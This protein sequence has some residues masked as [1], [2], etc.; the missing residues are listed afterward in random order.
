MSDKKKKRTDMLRSSLG[1]HFAGT[2]IVKPKDWDD[3]YIRSRGVKMVRWGMFSTDYLD[4]D[5]KKAF[6]KYCEE[7]SGKV[8]TYSIEDLKKAPE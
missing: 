4:K 8:N 1:G 3:D 7:Q 2:G 5:D 6:Q